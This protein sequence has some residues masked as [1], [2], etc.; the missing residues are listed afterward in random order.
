MTGVHNDIFYRNVPREK[1][2]WPVGAMFM[3]CVGRVL[4]SEVARN[5]AVEVHL[6]LNPH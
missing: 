2:P 5:V 1:G 6:G 3:A 4:L